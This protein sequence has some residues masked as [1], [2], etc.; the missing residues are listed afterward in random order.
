[1][2]PKSLASKR[3]WV[4]SMMISMMAAKRLDA[5]VARIRIALVKFASIYDCH[6]CGGRCFAFEMFFGVDLV[7][8]VDPLAF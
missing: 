3:P 6:H 5:E 8:S 4:I 1:M 7:P 2:Q